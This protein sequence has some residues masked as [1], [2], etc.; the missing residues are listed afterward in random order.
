MMDIKFVDDLSVH[1]G[2]IEFVDEPDA[3]GQRIRHRLLTFR[4][5][6]FLDLT[7]GVPYREQIFVKNPR[8]EVI[9]AILRAEILKS[10]DGQ[11]TS[12]SSDL[13]S[14]TRKLTVSFN[15]ET[16]QGPIAEVVTI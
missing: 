12:F 7:F 3:T 8:Q 4:A 2:D 10:A 6:W 11:I 14:A 13:N 15:L 1:D 9:G 5:E 16:V